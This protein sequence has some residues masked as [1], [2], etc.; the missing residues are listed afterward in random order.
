MNVRLHLIAPKSKLSSREM[1]YQLLHQPLLPKTWEWCGQQEALG[2]LH[3]S[4]RWARGPE[5]PPGPRQC[6]EVSRASLTTC[7]SVPLGISPLE[8][9][10]LPRYLCAGCGCCSLYRLSP[11]PPVY[12]CYPHS[13]PGQS[14]LCPPQERFKEIKEPGRKIM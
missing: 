4:L 1:R 8:P 3:L 5:Q 10:L 12:F 9:P 7:L 2:S 13:V 11:Q 6:G 14:A